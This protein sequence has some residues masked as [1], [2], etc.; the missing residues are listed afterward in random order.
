[1]NILFNNICGCLKNKKGFTLVEL[2]VVVVI[3]GILAAIAVPMYTSATE[4]SERRAVEANLRTIDGAI[5]QFQATHDGTDPADL[6]ALVGV[7]IQN[8][9]TGPGTATYALG[10]TPLRGQVTSTA[11]VGG[12]TLAGE[13]LPITWP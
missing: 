3:L 5:S 7:N 9:P 6:A 8:T 12:K 1:M 4:Q 10:G 13:S 2:M 11:N